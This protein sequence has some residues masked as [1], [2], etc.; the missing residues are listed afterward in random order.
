[1]LI[2]EKTES[3]ENQAKIRN[4]DLNEF[5]QAIPHESMIVRVEFQNKN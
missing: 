5:V 2:F 3:P 1:M 4:I